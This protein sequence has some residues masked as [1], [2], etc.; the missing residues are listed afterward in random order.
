MAQIADIVV[1][2]NPVIHTDEYSLGN[3]TSTDCFAAATYLASS[4]LVAIDAATEIKVAVGFDGTE[5][6]DPTA[7][8]TADTTGIGFDCAVD[9]SLVL[10]APGGRHK[11][12]HIKI[13]NDS[14]TPDLK[15]TY[16]Q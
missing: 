16:L 8:A 11:I 10:R 4:V 9:S 13:Y 15:V 2:P 1:S 6:S 3:N 12:S 7:T 5:P 14:G